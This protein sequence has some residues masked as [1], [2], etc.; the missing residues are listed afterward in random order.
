M[1]RATRNELLVLNATETTITTASVTIRTLRVGTKQLTQAVF[2]QLPTR[3]LVDEDTL[4][5]LGTVWGWV[6][7]NPDPIW[8]GRQFVAQF[9]EELCRCPLH[10]EKPIQ[11]K[12]RLWV[13]VNWGSGPAQKRVYLGSGWHREIHP[14]DV[15]AWLELC[16]RLNAAPQLFIAV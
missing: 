5:I 2:R 8:N 15:A 11:E 16:D 3:D 14:D 7:Y 4:K 10:L 6:N 1:S 12:G 13:R 9:G